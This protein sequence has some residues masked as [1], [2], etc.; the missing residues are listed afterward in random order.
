GSRSD[1]AAE[2]SDGLALDEKFSYVIDAKGNR[3]TVSILQGDKLLAKKTVDMT[4]SGYDVYNE[5]LY[6]KAGV[7]IQDSTGEPDDYAQATFYELEYE[8]GP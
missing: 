4:H 3:L 7:Y 2:P 8:H 1:D 6:F 5:Y